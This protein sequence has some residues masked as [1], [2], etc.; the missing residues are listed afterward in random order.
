[1]DDERMK[2]PVGWDYFDE[3]LERI[4][5]IR[6]SEKRFYRKVRD[7]FALSVD[8]QDNTEKLQYFFAEV[9]NKMLHAV[10]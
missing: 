7:L 2:D 3:L 5:E 10:T 6:V 4:R 9:Q 8:Y 1:M